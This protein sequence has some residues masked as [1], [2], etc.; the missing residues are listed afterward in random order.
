MK[1][2][3]LYTA[4]AILFALVVYAFV[5][6]ELVVFDGYAALGESLRTADRGQ[7]ICLALCVELMPVNL[8]LEAWKWQ[9]L[10]RRIAPMTHREALRQVYTGMA[11]AFVTPYR[12][13]DYPAR[14]LLL[15]PKEQWLPALGM[16]LVGSFAL[17]LVIVVCG[18]PALGA[19]FTATH[20]Q[21]LVGVF[22]AAG[23]LLLLLTLSPL[24]Q[25]LCRRWGAKDK[26]SK[27]RLLFSELG[28][29]SGKEFASVC[30]LSLLRYLC[31]SLQLL[32]A[33]R[34][35]GVRLAIIQWLTA[36][37]L[38]YLLV[39]LSPNI[40]MADAG[41]RGAWAIFVFGHF[42]PEATIPAALA[43]TI[44]WLTNTVLP[45]VFGAIRLPQ[46]EKRKHN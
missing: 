6:Y 18:L 45:V 4:L 5:G 29:T 25:R 40:P 17:T 24:L 14:I 46:R 15:K 13:G 43:A 37:P 44:L 31:F 41:I 33:L 30:G 19:F 8:W 10:L 35:C 1:K 36:I 3:H 9:Y 2:N 22:V 26:Q 11:G 27:M 28:K 38:Y 20:L 39:T 7:Y 34:F 42:S 12:I 23:G 16:A 32:L 21:P